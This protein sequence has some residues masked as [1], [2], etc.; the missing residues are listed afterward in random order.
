MDT[1]LF[2][3]MA[4]A[5]PQKQQPGPEDQQELVPYLGFIAILH[6]L[7]PLAESVGHT[8]DTFSGYWEAQPAESDGEEDVLPA[9]FMAFKAVAQAADGHPKDEPAFPY[10][11]PPHGAPAPAPVAPA[12]PFLDD[13]DEEAEGALLP[14]LAFAALAHFLFYDV[15]TKFKSAGPA[16]NPWDALADALRGWWEL[17]LHALRFALAPFNGSRAGASLQ[18]T[19]KKS[20]SSEDLASLAGQ[21]LFGAGKGQA[22]RTVRVRTAL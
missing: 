18:D 11:P 19:T 6:A 12:A 9:P 4:P 15:T 8:Y 2:E 22:A 1:S 3:D 20:I 7:S 5:Q 16:K 13:M 14:Y 10:G 21:K 17:P